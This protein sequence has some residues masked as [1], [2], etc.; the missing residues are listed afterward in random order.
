[1]R[2][3]KEGGGRER[4]GRR[5]DGAKERELGMRTYVRDIRSL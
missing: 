4:R 5:R 2:E 3:E 1:M